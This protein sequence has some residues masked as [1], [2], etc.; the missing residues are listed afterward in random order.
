MTHNPSDIPE[1]HPE[2]SHMSDTEWMIKIKREQLEYAEKFS[3]SQLDR[4]YADKII[5]YF[6]D[7]DVSL[8]LLPTQEQHDVVPE[9]QSLLVRVVE[10][11][12]RV[13]DFAFGRNAFLFI[14][15]AS[16]ENTMNDTQG[17]IAKDCNVS[18]RKT[19]YIGNGY[20]WPKNSQF[21]ELSDFIPV[22][23]E[24]KFTVPVRQ[25]MYGSSDDGYR[26]V[27]SIED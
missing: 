3:F 17:I 11:D 25:V 27:F 20:L 1:M 16:V 22:G 5:L 4:P 18:F 13:F 14:D 24:S 8:Q 9:N 26:T 21:P 15:G 7:A 19:E 2:I 12:F 23:L 6:D 10:G